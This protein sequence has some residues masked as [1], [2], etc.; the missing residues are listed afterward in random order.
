MAEA[1]VAKGGARTDI[2]T[3]EVAHTLWVLTSYQYDLLVAEA[4]WSEKRYRAWLERV[5]VEAVLM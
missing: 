3:D 1:K 4:G 5:V 2:S